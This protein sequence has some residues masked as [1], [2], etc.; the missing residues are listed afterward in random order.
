MSAFL[1]EVGYA[2]LGDLVARF[3]V[4]VST[5]RRDLEEMQQKGIVQ[6]THGGAFHKEVREHPLDYARRQSMCPAEKQAIGELAASF[7][8]D[9]ETVLLDGGTTTFEVACRLRDRPL[10]VVTNSLPVATLLSTSPQTQVVLLG[11]SI[12]PR[13]G[14]VVGR[15]AEEMLRTLNVSR[16]VM[17]TAGITE[18]GLFNANLLMVELERLMIQAADEVIVVVDH[19]KFDRRSLVRLC[20]FGD[21]D[22]LVTDGQV[23]DRWTEVIRSRGVKLHLAGSRRDDENAAAGGAIHTS[24]S[25]K[26]E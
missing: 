6:R 10:Q 12:M 17:G 16:A 1:E 19:T 9:G 26:R 15:H 2:S 13:T 23:P 11:G 25:E 7:I 8:H 20:D 22:H 24:D 14:V 21:V 4:S 5:V 18:Q 3:G